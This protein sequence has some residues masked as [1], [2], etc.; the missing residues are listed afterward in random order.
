[1]LFPGQECGI[2]YELIGVLDGE[3]GTLIVVAP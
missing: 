3:S 1:M 2:Q